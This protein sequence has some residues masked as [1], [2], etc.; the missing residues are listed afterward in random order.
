MVSIYNKN[1]AEKGVN[2][3]VNKASS[4]N[5]LLNKERSSQEVEPRNEET[6]CDPQPSI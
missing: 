2:T 5:E 4:N 3:D 1:N 6:D